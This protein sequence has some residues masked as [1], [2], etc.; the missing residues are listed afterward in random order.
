MRT[1]LAAFLLLASR[2]AMA[3]SVDVQQ[4]GAPWLSNI[5]TPRAAAMGGAHAAVATSNDAIFSNPAGLAQLR[6]YHFEVDGLLDTGFPAQG[7]VLSVADSTTGPVATGFTY[8]HFGSGRDDGRA[9]GWLLGAAYAYNL[10][11]FYFGG[12]TKYLRFNVPLSGASPDGTVHQ[13]MQD[14]G[15]LV[16]RGDLSWAAVVQNISTS[17]HPLFPLTAVGGVQLGSDQS[18]HL[19]L[20]YRADLGDTSRVK[21]K[22]AAGYEMLIDAFALRAGGTYDVTNSLWWVSAG[23][24]LL[25]EKGGVQLVYRRRLSGDVDHVF[26]GGVTLYLE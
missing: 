8:A 10:G 25:T 9:Q 14:L 12:L 2:A 7:L 6:R 16:K 13:F 1:L 22:L 4:P 21:H 15:I 20:D 18:S 11:S 17:P 26:E 19:A 5:V 23:L 24:G 3:Q